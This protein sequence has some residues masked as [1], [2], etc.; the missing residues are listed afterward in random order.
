MPDCQCGH[1]ESAHYDKAGRCK[2]K[3]CACCLYWPPKE[4]PQRPPVGRCAVCGGLRNVGMHVRCDTSGY[5]G[6]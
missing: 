5:E 3:G 6:L 4:A 1:P 2:S